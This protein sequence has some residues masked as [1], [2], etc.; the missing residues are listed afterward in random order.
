VITFDAKESL[1]VAT[2]EVA[3]CPAGQFNVTVVAVISVS[4]FTALRMFS[5]S[6]ST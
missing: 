3:V 1:F 6:V 4:S 2:I 5:A